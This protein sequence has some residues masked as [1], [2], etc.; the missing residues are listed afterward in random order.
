MILFCM[1]YMCWQLVFGLL[2]DMEDGSM[3]KLVVEVVF[4]LEFGDF[5][6]FFCYCVFSVDLKNGNV[7]NV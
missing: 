3:G 7:L 1:L 4:S 2:V 5:V 6:M